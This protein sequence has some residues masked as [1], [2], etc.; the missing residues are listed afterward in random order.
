MVR[1]IIV[2]TL[3]AAGLGIHFFKSAES[4]KAQFAEDL[5]EKVLLTQDVDIEF[6][7]FSHKNE[8]EDNTD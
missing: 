2:V 1:G 3:V 5:I 7:D 4:K 8:K 6:D